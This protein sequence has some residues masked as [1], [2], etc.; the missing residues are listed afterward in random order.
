MQ[1]LVM[2]YA[3]S[4]PEN[5]R[6]WPCRTAL[7]CRTGSSMSLGQLAQLHVARMICAIPSA[8]SCR[9]DLGLLHS[10]QALAQ[11]VLCFELQPR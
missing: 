6:S 4:G 8:L 11:G 3:H 1:Q 10:Q 2:L 5:A 7:K 9:G